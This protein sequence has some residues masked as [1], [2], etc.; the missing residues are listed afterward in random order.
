L[1]ADVTS[2]SRQVPLLAGSEISAIL[3]ST[4]GA[5]DQVV[6]TS[7]QLP[8]TPCTSPACG[9]ESTTNRR[10]VAELTV[11]PSGISLRSNR[12]RIRFTSEPS[13][14]CRVAFRP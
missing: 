3:L 11:V 7:T 13:T 6:E 14:A 1:T 12:M 9:D 2:A 10:R 4:R 5:D 8:T